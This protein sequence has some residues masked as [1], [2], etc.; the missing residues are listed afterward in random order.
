[1]NHADVEKFCLSL[2]GAT[3]SVQWGEE[4][5]YKVG[6]KMFAMQGP[7]ADRPHHLYFKA[8]EMSYE[9]LTRLKHIIP[10]PYLARAHWVYLER[11]DALKG[12]ELKGYLERAHAQVAAGLPKKKRAELGMDPPPKEDGFTLRR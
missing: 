6:G 5:V 1:M 8:G 3:L 11:L 12:K 9:I 10:A 2:P 7:K 4:R